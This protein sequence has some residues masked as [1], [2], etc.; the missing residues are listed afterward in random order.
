MIGASG[1]SISTARYRWPD[2]AERARTCSAVDIS[3]PVSSPRTV[4]NSVAV[5][6]SMSAAISRSRRPLSMG[7]DKTQTGIGVRRVQCQRHRQAGMDADTDNAVRSRSVVCLQPTFILPSHTSLPAWAD[8]RHGSSHWQRGR[9]A[10]IGEAEHFAG[11]V[12][13]TLSPDKNPFPRNISW[14]SA[15]VQLTLFYG[16]LPSCGRNRAKLTVAKRACRSVPPR[17]AGNG[18][19]ARP[20]RIAAGNGRQRSP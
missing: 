17:Q 6:A 11:K 20:R 18:S 9:F 2:R 16:L 8:Q 1:P 7:T 12:S 10:A 15:E 13:A 14:C 4:A 5:T 19:A 3:G